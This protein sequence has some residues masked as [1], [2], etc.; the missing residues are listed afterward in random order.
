MNLTGLAVTV[1]PGDG[2]ARIHRIQMAGMLG[3]HIILA[4]FGIAFPVVLL[5]AEHLG[6]PL[7]A[8]G[9]FFPPR[10]CSPRSACT[11][12]G[13][14]RPGRT[15]LIPPDNHP[16]RRGQRCRHGVGPPALA[17]NTVAAGPATA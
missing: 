5:A 13:G 7:A 4:C 16:C 6:L 15:M 8:E 10:R 11:G 17:G 1:A 12:G 2:A 9:V 14:S 3:F